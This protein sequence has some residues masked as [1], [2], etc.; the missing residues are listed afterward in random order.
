MY[1]HRIG[2]FFNKQD[3]EIQMQI[4]MERLVEKV[5]LNPDVCVVE[6]L[7]LQTD[8]DK[9]Y[10]A[11]VCD[12]YGLEAAVICGGLEMNVI[13]K[14]L[15]Q[16]NGTTIAMP[17][18]HANIKERCAWTTHDEAVAIEKAH[19][20]IEMAIAR[21]SYARPIALAKRQ[22][23]RCVMVLGASHSAYR[24]SLELANS[25][26][27]V[28]L[29]ATDQP[30]GC[31]FPILIT[32]ETEV[33]NH[34]KIT[35]VSEGKV[36]A[37]NGS[38]GNFHVAIKE[39]NISTGYHVG[40]IVI[41]IDA[42]AV[43]PVEVEQNPNFVTLKQFL[44]DVRHCE[45]TDTE[46]TIWL[47]KNGPERKCAARA[48]IEGA[49]DYAEKGGNIN[50]LFRNIPVFGDKGQEIYNKAQ[51]HGVRFLRYA[52]RLPDIG[53]SEEKLSVTIVDSVIPSQNITMESD[54]VVIP[55]IIRPCFDNQAIAK[56]VR[57]PLD[58]EGFLQPGNIKHLPI[59][60]ARKGIIF[61][62]GCHSEC[63]PNEFSTEASAVLAEVLKLLP[64]APVTVPMEIVKI[65]VGKCASC[66]SCLRVCPHGAIEQRYGKKSVTIFDTACWECGICAATCPSEA[67]DHGGFSKQQMKQIIKV[68]S[69][70]LLDTKPIVVFAC[71]Q[72]A[73]QAL[74]EAGR[75]GLSVPKNI[76]FIEVPC[77]GRVDESSLLYALSSGAEKVVVF[78]CHEDVCRSLKGNLLA[79]E[80]VKRLNKM[81]DE[82]GFEQNSLEYYSIAA[83]E[84]YRMVNLL[85][86]VSGN[87]IGEN[88]TETLS[89]QEK[90]NPQWKGN[91]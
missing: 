24:A 21:A 13:E 2:V 44:M 72:S 17:M 50:L 55:S 73:V 76:Q 28:V 88:E 37:I 27:D 61:C 30:S 53:K 26:F 63:D 25:G 12:E 11:K 38:C 56:M 18:I 91:L 36:H 85:D 20:I 54:K 39:G 3:K 42:N 10:I 40:A 84:P 43:T 89:Q 90:R 22:A 87:C 48:A 23:N 60:S 62:G 47:D 83:N 9:Q 65:D 49:T 46:Y 75:L 41:A 1:S 69:Q 71:Q 32:L 57:Q 33:E 77:A 68:A 29:H 34:Q 45:T 7:D 74:D 82:T 19:R 8:E 6:M 79:K 58:A 66:L 64:I 35:I 31:F 67:I 80:R 86:K 70:P 52:D 51:Q 5:E 15:I 14:P 78:A 81:F 59:S 4:N 16:N